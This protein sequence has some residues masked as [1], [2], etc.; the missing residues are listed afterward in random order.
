[1]GEIVEKRPSDQREVLGQ[2]KK[3][4]ETSTNPSAT[5]CKIAR[6][7]IDGDNL[8]DPPERRSERPPPPPSSRGGGGGDRGGDRDRD[9]RDRSRD[10]S[11]D[12]DR[13]DGSRDRGRRRY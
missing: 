12:R 2:I 8:P 13:R 5:L 7:V 1:M 6:G 10:R 9:R 4:L 3:H 11:R